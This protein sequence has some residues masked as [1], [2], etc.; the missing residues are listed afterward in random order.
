MVK[1]ILWMLAILAVIFIVAV[2]AKSVAQGDYDERQEIARG[3]AFRYAY[4]TLILYF[5]ISELTSYYLQHNWCNGLTNV[6][7]GICLSAVVFGAIAIWKD[8]YVKLNQKAKNNAAIMG[9]I[10]FLNVIQ[11]II[12]LI[13]KDPGPV[14]IP[15]NLSIGVCLLFL[16]V[17]SIIKTKMD[18]NEEE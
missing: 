4:F 13:D 8:A 3:S 18:K 10:G 7:C 2:A 9:A 11:G 12:S 6:I 17:F 1:L 5:I 16:A 15:I 14:S